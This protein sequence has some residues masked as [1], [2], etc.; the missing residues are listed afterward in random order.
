MK[1]IP[2]WVWL[3][4]GAALLYYLYSQGYLS[5]LLP[6]AATTATTATVTGNAMANPSA[7]GMSVFNQYVAEGMIPAGTTYAN[8]TASGYPINVV[9][10][11]A[12]YSNDVNVSSL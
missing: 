12:S 6:A 3:A 8:W 11:P 1:D 4:A 7:T 5:T 10:T 9:G 2:S